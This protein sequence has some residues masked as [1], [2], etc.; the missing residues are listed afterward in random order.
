[1]NFFFF[2]HAF[3]FPFKTV[4]GLKIKVKKKK[5]RLKTWIRTLNG[6]N[7]SNCHPF[8]YFPLTSIGRLK[9]D[10]ILSTNPLPFLCGSRKSSNVISKNKIFF[11]F[12]ILNFPLKF[13]YEQE[14]NFGVFWFIWIIKT[15]DHS[16]KKKFKLIKCESFRRAEK[17]GLFTL[18]KWLKTKNE[19]L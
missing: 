16:E 8:Y 14:I 5:K 15:K 9:S 2:T 11:F 12:L 13:S 6:F 10:I 3:A 4:I 18:G 1:M 19:N 7:A 17:A